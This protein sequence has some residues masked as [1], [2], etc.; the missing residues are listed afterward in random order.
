VRPHYIYVFGLRNHIMDIISG[1]REN[2][3]SRATTVGDIFRVSDKDLDLLQERRE[4]LLRNADAS[5][6]KH[7]KGNGCI[8]D[9]SIF[10]YA[11]DSEIFQDVSRQYWSA[12]QE[13]YEFIDDIE[14]VFTH[15]DM[16]LDCYMDY[17]SDQF[18]NENFELSLAIM[19]DEDWEES[20]FPTEMREMCD[21]GRCA[22]HARV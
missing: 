1:C 17:N 20:S 19:N 3:P 6:P 18:S 14:I 21:P 13:S 22:K 16:K 9:I 5:L 8:S 2:E 10:Y 11:N 15:T 4:S 7:S 12:L